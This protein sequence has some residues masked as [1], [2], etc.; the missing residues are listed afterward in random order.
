VAIL[1]DPVTHALVRSTAGGMLAVVFAAQRP[2]DTARVAQQ[3]AG[4]ERRSSSAAPRV[5]PSDGWRFLIA[6]STAS[7]GEPHASILWAS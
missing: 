5:T 6:E 2:A 3:R 7:A 1:V 4:D